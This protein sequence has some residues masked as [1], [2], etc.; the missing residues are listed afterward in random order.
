MPAVDEPLL[1]RRQL[2]DS[3]QWDFV[4]DLYDTTMD[5]TTHHGIEVRPLPGRG[6]G[7]VATMPLARGERVIAEAPLHRWVRAKGERSDFAKLEHSVDAL[8]PLL[9]AAF[10]SLAD[11]A[12]CH[13]KTARGIW[14]TNSFVTEDVLG[15]G[16]GRSSD[17]IHRAA[18]FCVASRFNHACHPNAFASWSATEDGG[19]MTVHTVREV[20]CGEELTI[21]YVAGAESGTRASRRALLKRKYHFECDCDACRLHGKRLKESDARHARLVEIHEA[22]ATGEDDASVVAL[23]EEQYALMLEEGVPLVL[24]KAGW[25]L[26]MVQLMQ[27]G[28]KVAAAQWASVGAECTRVALGTDSSAYLHFARLLGLDEEVGATPCATRAT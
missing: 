27:R 10:Y 3:T 25:I 12:A 26:A 11:N 23:V 9:W 8:P 1:A 15:G 6:L 28:D 24:G 20:A 16:G 19:R 7:I 22:L 14:N 5:G 21:S 17:G 4:R 2:A 18:V 13:G